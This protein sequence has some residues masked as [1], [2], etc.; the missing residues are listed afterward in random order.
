[1]ARLSLIISH[2]SS[3]FGV[4]AP[5]S[6]TLAMIA[7]IVAAKSKLL[8]KL[9]IGAKSL[10]KFSPHPPSLAKRDTLRKRR[11]DCRTHVSDYARHHMGSSSSALVSHI[12][13][14]PSPLA[15]ASVE[16]P[17]SSPSDVDREP[18]LSGVGNVSRITH[19]HSQP[20][21]A[22]SSTVAGRQSE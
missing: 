6:R 18:L 17:I 20:Y 22:V 11:L 5:A 10:R 21:L 3:S 14:F 1:M 13:P 2:L 19:I 9:Q 15:S 8:D 4:R 7:G 16:S 12:H